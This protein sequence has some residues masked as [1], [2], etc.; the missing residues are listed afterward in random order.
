M[1]RKLEKKIEKLVAEVVD[2]DLAQKA[3]R[4]ASKLGKGSEWEEDGCPSVARSSYNFMNRTFRIFSEGFGCW[5]FS[6]D[7]KINYRGDLVFEGFWQPDAGTLWDPVK[8]YI[9]G[10]WLISFERLYR[11][12]DK[13]QK[14]ENW[15]EELR[16]RNL[17]MGE[18]LKLR[19]GFGL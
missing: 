3:W 16:M 1:D 10:D 12:A 9:P 17:E 11:R 4:I 8:A 6:A 7:S 13:I 5:G 15:A 14:A 2:K 18:E 19:K